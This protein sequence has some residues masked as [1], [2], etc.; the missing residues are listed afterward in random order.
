MASNTSILAAFER[1]W[2]H[3]ITAL[4]GKA[5]ASHTHEEYVNN[6]NAIEFVGVDEDGNEHTWT[7]Y[8]VEQ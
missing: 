8:G 6:A 2:M 4:G 5:E 3:I 7:V 1:M